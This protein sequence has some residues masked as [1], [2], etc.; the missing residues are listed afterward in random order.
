MGE[1]AIGAVQGPT[2]IRVNPVKLSLARLTTGA[3][4]NAYAKRFGSITAERATLEG[5]SYIEPGYG[6]GY[7]GFT[8]GLSCLEHGNGALNTHCKYQ[9]NENGEL[10]PPTRTMMLMA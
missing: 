5:F 3:A 8:A 7:N 6:D 10:V 4:E 9:M 2:T 1:Q